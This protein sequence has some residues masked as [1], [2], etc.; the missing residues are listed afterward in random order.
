MSLPAGHFTA[1]VPGDGAAQMMPAVHSSPR[2]WRWPLNRRCDRQVGATSMVNRVLRSTRVPIALAHPAPRIRS[3]S[4]CP[5]TARS[6]TT[7]GRWLI[8]ITLTEASR[9][10]RYCPEA[11]GLLVWSTSTCCRSARSWPRPLHVETLVDGFVA[12]PCQPVIGV[13]MRQHLGDQLRAPPVV[14]PPFDGGAQ[15]RVVELEPLGPLGVLRGPG[16]GHSGRDSPHRRCGCAAFH[17]QIVV[18]S[19]P[20]LL[21]DRGVAEP[22]VVA[23]HDRDTFTDTEPMTRATGQRHI[24]RIGDPAA[25]TSN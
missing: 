25:L 21:G 15:P 4:Q 12:H 24:S 19:R 16:M 7:A 8:V 6:S 10:A 3:P 9:G 11:Y 1:A 14:H 23:A 22:G 5:G 18:R 2:S 13:I 20:S 17:G